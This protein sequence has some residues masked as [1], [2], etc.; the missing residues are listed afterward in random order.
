MQVT[1]GTTPR[2]HAFPENATPVLVANVTEKDNL[3]KV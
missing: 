1:R 2:N 3:L